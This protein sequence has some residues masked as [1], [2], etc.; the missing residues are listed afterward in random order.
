[1]LMMK[2]FLTFLPSISLTETPCLPRSGILTCTRSF[3][4]GGGG[5]NA[6]KFLFNRFS[7]SLENLFTY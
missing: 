5:G 6:S 1:M 2:F 4:A 3:A 7:G